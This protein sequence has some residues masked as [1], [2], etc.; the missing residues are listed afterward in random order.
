MLISG[1]AG[2]G[3]SRACLE[4]LHLLAEL[5]PGFRGLILRRT[6][7]SLTNAALVTWEQHVVPEGHPCLKGPQR[8]QRSVYR[9]PNGSEVAVGGL[10]KPGKVMSSEWDAVYVQEATELGED[11]W[12]ALTTRLR[13]GK[14]PYQQLLAD[15]NPDAP[16]HWL[17]RRCDRRQTQILESRHEDNPVLWDAARGDWTERGRVYISKL[18]ALTGPRKDRLRHGRWVQAEGLVYEGWNPALH[19]VDPFPIPAGWPRFWSV[20]FGYTNPFVCQFWAADPDGRLYRYREVYKTRRLVEEHAARIA[21]LTR[22]EP[23]PV[24]IFCD[25]DAEDRAT[26]ERHWGLALTPA[27]KAVGPGLQAVANRL[28]SAGDGRPRLFLLRDSTDERDADLEDARKPCSTE[29]EFDGYV[30]NDRSRKEEPVKK[31]DHGLDALRYLVQS[32]DGA[33]P[34]GEEEETSYARAGG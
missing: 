15:C 26:L 1:P 6:R 8:E 22:R 31:D 27:N 11:G 19:L 3:K 10:D 25:H 18:D 16:R 29:E 30:W 12:E 17:K 28:K 20:D 14:A 24:A 33:P 7:R 23:L 34:A 5:V 32:L 2:T 4:K 9:Y 21:A 13:N